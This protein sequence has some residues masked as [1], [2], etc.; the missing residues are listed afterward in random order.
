MQTF[1]FGSDFSISFSVFRFL[2]FALIKMQLHV[3][4]Y[5]EETTSSLS[6][7][8]C[9]F[10]AG[11]FSSVGPSSTCG[12]PG[13]ESASAA[14]QRA[15]PSVVESGGR[16]ACSRPVT[17]RTAGQR[18]AR[19]PPSSEA[20]SFAVWQTGR[21]QGRDSSRWE[22][23]KPVSHG[24]LGSVLRNVLPCLMRESVGV[25]GVVPPRPVLCGSGASSARQVAP[26]A[27]SHQRGG[28]HQGRVLSPAQRRAGLSASS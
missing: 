28:R 7:P 3:P 24:S 6:K 11:P 16:S 14:T 4:R 22:F 12:C 15:P 10:E 18:E 26:G 27:L 17:L 21:V 5:W 19:V 20:A 8:S 13:A 9:R 2:W 1:I 25:M 23:G